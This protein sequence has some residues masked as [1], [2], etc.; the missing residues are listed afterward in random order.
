ME[1]QCH[2]VDEWESALCVALGCSEHW[3]PLWGLPRPPRPTGWWLHTSNTE[4]VLE[5]WALW[6]LF[7]LS[8]R[9]RNSEHRGTLRH[10]GQ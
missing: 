10:G 6:S 1:Q 8:G 2:G 4:L 3:P 5:S 7:W 9:T